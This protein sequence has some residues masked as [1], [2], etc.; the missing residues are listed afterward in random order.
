MPR[1]YLAI[2]PVRAGNKPVPPRPVLKWRILAAHVNGYGLSHHRGRG[3]AN[4]IGRSRLQHGSCYRNRGRP[5]GLSA[6]VDRSHP[7]LILHPAH[8]PPL[9]GIG[10]GGRCV[11]APLERDESV[12]WSDSDLVT[13]RVGDCVPSDGKASVGS[14]NG[15]F[16]RRTEHRRFNATRFHLVGSSFD[17]HAASG[18][19]RHEQKSKQRNSGANFS[20]GV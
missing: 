19:Q 15:D 13:R 1:Q 10:R 16:G 20:G 9:D 4:R 6:G 5:L 12:F 7:H 3:T 14:T 11:F 17:V 8:R 18:S 2:R